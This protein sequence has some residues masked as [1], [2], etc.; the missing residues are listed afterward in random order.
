MVTKKW[1]SGGVTISLDLFKLDVPHK[2][3][4]KIN[5]NSILSTYFLYLYLYLY[6]LNDIFVVLFLVVGGSFVV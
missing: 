1:M 4:K 3:K 2:K 6:L 5:E